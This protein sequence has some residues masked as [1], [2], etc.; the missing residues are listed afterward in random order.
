LPIL[1]EL[2]RGF[3]WFFIHSKTPKLL[4]VDALRLY[5]VT[6]TFFEPGFSIGDIQEEQIEAL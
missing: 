3:I 6:D 4:R 2:K 1:F 5:F